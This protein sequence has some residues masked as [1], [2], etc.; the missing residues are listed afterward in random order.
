MTEEEAEEIKDCYLPGSSGVGGLA[1]TLNSDYRGKKV[2][3]EIDQPVNL[4]DVP[5]EMKENKYCL[6]F[7][8]ETEKVHMYV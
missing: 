2:E 1:G 3:I 6:Q 4:D 5:E 8:V 7:E